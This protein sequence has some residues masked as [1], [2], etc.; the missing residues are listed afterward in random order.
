MYKYFYFNWYQYLLVSKVYHVFQLVSQIS[1]FIW[2][3]N[4]VISQFDLLKKKFKNLY[5]LISIG[6]LKFCLCTKGI[7]KCVLLPWINL[8]NCVKNILIRIAYMQG[9]LTSLLHIDSCWVYLILR[10]LTTLLYAIYVC[11]GELRISS[12]AMHIMRYV[13]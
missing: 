8:K 9:E 1:Y 7:S 3:Q 2:Y 11:R 12:Y 6:I 5:C 13:S 10:S 4:L